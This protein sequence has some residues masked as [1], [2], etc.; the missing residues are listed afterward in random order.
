MTNKF[1]HVVLPLKSYRR[2]QKFINET[3][4]GQGWRSNYNRLIG[5]AKNEKNEAHT[6]VHSL[7]LLLTKW[8]INEI[9]IFQYEKLFL[10]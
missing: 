6:S 5:N 1:I 4:D 7:F 10:W 2:S 9:Q 3:N 8:N